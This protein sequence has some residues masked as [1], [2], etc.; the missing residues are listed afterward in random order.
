MKTNAILLALLI[1]CMSL[2]GCVSQTDGV[3][4]VTLTDEQVDSIVDEHLDEFL[5][6]MTIVVN[7]DITNHNNN[8]YNSN[9]NLP[10]VISVSVDQA[11][12]F[13]GID[14]TTEGI[15]IVQSIPSK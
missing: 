1:F 8:T 3:A 5:E 10:P 13:D 12:Y 6:N 2:A 11:T 15:S 9:G 7:E 14:C 4:E